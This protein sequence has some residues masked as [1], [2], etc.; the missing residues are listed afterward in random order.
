MAGSTSA[1]RNASGHGLSRLKGV[2]MTVSRDAV[3][4]GHQCGRK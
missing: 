3:S 4:V 2:W 1:T